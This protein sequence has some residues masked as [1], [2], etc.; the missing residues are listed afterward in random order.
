M[1]RISCFKSIAL[2]A[3]VLSFTA[4]FSVAANK[5]ASIDSIKVICSPELKSLAERWATEYSAI[6]PGIRVKVLNAS[7]G[8]DAA[9]LFKGNVIGLV[10]DS[11]LPEN[12]SRTAWKMV[13]GRDVIVPVFNSS[14]PYLKEINEQGISVE[15]LNRFLTK[16]G[17]GNWGTLLNGEQKE[18]ATYYILNEKSVQ[19]NLN[20]FLKTGQTPA[21]SLFV[22]NSND[23][24][25]AVQGDPFAIGFCK[26]GNLIDFDNQNF[27]QGVSLLP[28]DRNGNG[29]LD[30]NEKI[31]DDFSSF[32][33]GVWIGKYPKSLITNI[34]AATTIQ[35]TDPKQTAFLGW[36]VSKGQKYLFAEGYSDLIS[37]ERQSAV[38]KL[39][40]IKVEPV[41][42][43][44]DNYLLKAILFV[45]AVLIAA[46][47]AID[48]VLRVRKASVAGVKS[49]M[50]RS[51]IFPGENAI[52]I[53]AGLYYDKTH[54]W[55][56]MDR[57]GVVTVG[58][59]DF[60]Q[61]V[62]GPISQIKM[63]GEGKKIKKG[64]Q[65]LAVVQNGKH[66]NLYAPVSGTITEQNIQLLNNSE[67]IN[68]SPYNDGWIYKIEPSNWLKENQLMFMADKQKEYIKRE[69]TRL[70][71][72]L[73]SA[74]NAA[75]GTLSPI[76]LQDGGEIKDGVLSDL[77]PEVWD[78]FQTKFI[79]PSR[80]IWFYDLF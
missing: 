32:L 72:F 5:S 26:M 62:T 7:T 24:I 4:S 29:K 55:A 60:L 59:D 48:A 64:D 75:T 56:F 65:I 47:F 1:K 51:G 19:D 68:N 43:S 2:M 78:D 34:Y 33:R 23:L 45:I 73:A 14:N 40:N 70:K 42:T 44:G 10:P 52:K 50:K 13:I 71:D 37:A 77:G 31:Y 46:G 41:Q 39:F 53:P 6:E 58:I 27:A 22:E 79:D 15:L 76:V 8:N 16:T 28:I 20:E 80:Q 9:M 3:A 74:F 63:K 17:A 38:D 67:L 25:A 21:G 49:E 54:T 35:T 11:F 12:M 66:L 69:F 30:Y 61:H 18:K 36:L 57:N